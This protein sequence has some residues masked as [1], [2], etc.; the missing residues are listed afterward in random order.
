MADDRI[1][2]AFIDDTL[3]HK[4]LV[5]C[6]LGQAAY[7]LMRRAVVHDNSKFEPEEAV[8]YSLITPRLKLLEYGSPDY[9]GALREM[10]P[11]VDHHYAANDHHPEHFGTVGV[12]GMNLFQ[13]H[14][15]VYD[16]IA[17]ARTTDRAEIERGFRVNQERFD[18]TPPLFEILLNTLHALLPDDEEVRDNG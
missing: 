15:M 1:S 10:K 4:R 8:L 3:A 2:P 18:I 5:A 14:E 13:L 16:W 7:E 12:E 6:Y 11:A 9:R 17:A